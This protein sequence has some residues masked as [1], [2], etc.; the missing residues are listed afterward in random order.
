MRENPGYVQ[1]SA[2]IVFALP[3]PKLIFGPCHSNFRTFVCLHKPLCGTSMFFSCVVIIV[4][5]PL[6]YLIL[7]ACVSAGGQLLEQACPVN[8]SVVG[9]CFVSEGETLQ[10]EMYFYGGK[11]QANNI[12]TISTFLFC[13][14]RTACDILFLDNHECRD[15]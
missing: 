1:K 5:C 10:S 11:H 12:F 8:S 7:I 14:V 15:T 2:P 9:A 13:V 4:R 3:K 6:W